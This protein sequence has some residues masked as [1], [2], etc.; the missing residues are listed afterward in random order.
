MSVFA[1]SG[2]S[3]SSG[4]SGGSPQLSSVTIANPVATLAST[5]YSY[6]LPAS[7]KVLKVRARGD[8]LLQISFTS[9]QTNTVFLSIYPGDTYE[10][11]V[12]PLDFSTTLYFRSSK[13]LEVLEIESWS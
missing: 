2:S 1:P 8:A 5:E 11:P 4:S 7:T 3:T 6:S 10:S 13:A 12:F 9:G